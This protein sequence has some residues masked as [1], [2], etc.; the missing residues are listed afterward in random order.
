MG[1]SSTA[2]GRAYNVGSGAG[3]KMVDLASQVIAIA[4][5]GRIEHVAWPPL[6]QQIE[7]GDFIADIDRIAEDLGW[8]PTI[9]LRQGL[10][11]TVAFYRAHAA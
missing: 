3:T 7:T 8:R 9:G 11:Q 5:T 2:D 6:A 1:E 10:E 4:G